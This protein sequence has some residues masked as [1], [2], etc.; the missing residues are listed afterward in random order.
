MK[1][2]CNSFKDYVPYFGWFVTRENICLMPHFEIKDRKLRVNHCP[3]CGAEVRSIQ[4]PKQE[5]ENL[6]LKEVKK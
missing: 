5:L 2:C 4:I 6:M 1:Y 3:S